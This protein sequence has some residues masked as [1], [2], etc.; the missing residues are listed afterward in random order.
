MRF[1]PDKSALVAF[2]LL[3]LIGC[4]R[5]QPKP[6]ETTPMVQSVVPPE[7]HIVHKTFSVQKYESFEIAIPA[8]CLHPRLHGNFKS[9]RYG[10][11][12][13]RSSD[14]AA[15]VDVL[16]LD[17]QQF[18]VFSS[19]PLEEGTRSAQNTHDQ[20]IDW[21]LPAS[22]NDDRKFYLVFNNATGKPKTKMIDADLTLSF[23]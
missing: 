11:Q 18:K 16:L 8:H 5:S 2:I 12:G 14:E 4:N 23:D 17:E 7:Q 10:E 3:A 15:N 9:F 22:Y 1:C 21:A 13:N 20:E 6:E 19:G